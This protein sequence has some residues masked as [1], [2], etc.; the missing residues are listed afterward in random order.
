MTRADMALSEKLWAEYGARW[1][2]PM[3]TATQAHVWAE[4][5]R[6]GYKTAEDI[7]KFLVGVA[8]DE[9][10]AA[11]H[12]TPGVWPH[13]WKA[14]EY[15]YMNFYATDQVYGGPEEGGWY[16]EAGTPLAS[17]PVPIDTL[18]DEIDKSY[19]ILCNNLGYVM[20]SPGHSFVVEA[21]Y[22]W[23]YPQERPHYE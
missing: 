8:F 2:L 11:E 16:Y 9:W 5:Q 22:G 21:D 18:Q 17:I 13:D 19:H 14:R 12:G 4:F 1:P 10:Y 7:P 20:G 3:H 15:K 6:R 23:P